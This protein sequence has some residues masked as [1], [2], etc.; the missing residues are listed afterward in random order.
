ML[1]AESLLGNGYLP[2]ELPPPFTSSGLGN[3]QQSLTPIRGF[4]G[5]KVSYL[6]RHS[7]P[8]AKLQRRILSIPNPYHHIQL[9]RALEGHWGTID[10]HIQRSPLSASRPV[11]PQDTAGSS[12]AVDMFRRM[13]YLSIGR[14]HKSV[15]AKYLLK[16]D[17]SNYYP[18]IYTHAIPWALHTKAVAKRDRTDGLIGNVIDRHLRQSQ[19]GQT[20]GI[21][22]GPD[23]SLIISEILG[24][25]LDID[26][27][28]RLTR[29]QGFRFVDDYYLYLQTLG[30]AERALENLE[31]VAN[32]YELRVNASKT[33][34]LPMPDHVQPRWVSE[35]RSFRFRATPSGQKADLVTYFS[36]AFEHAVNCPLCSY[37]CAKED[38]G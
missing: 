17:I 6:C 20:I 11:V 16:T 28:S 8:K 13:S 4:D 27:V 9:C 12:R 38:Q 26:L 10:A 34:I 36:M 35:L 30:E 7:I 14:V 23:S 33:A 18:S 32:S 24:S 21:P 1:T 19:D 22:V 5:R 31:A 2:S 15:A 25:A 29:P 37:I 3:V